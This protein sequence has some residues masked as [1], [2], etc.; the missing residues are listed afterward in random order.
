M[1]PFLCSRDEVL[2][3]PDKRH[4]V[5][6]IVV[7][8]LSEDILVL[9]RVIFKKNGKIITKG[10]SSDCPDLPLSSRD[11]LGRA[12]V[13]VRNGVESSLESWWPRFFGLGLNLALY[14]FPSLWR[15]LAAG[16]RIWQKKLA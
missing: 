10:D 8:K 5:G 14:W 9:H 1:T 6:D 12:V 15:V 13:R 7:C 11:I 3:V 16:K 4:R 2:V